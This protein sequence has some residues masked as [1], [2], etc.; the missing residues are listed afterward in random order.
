[1]CLPIPNGFQSVPL[2]KSSTLFSTWIARKPLE[3][4]R[5]LDWN[6]SIGPS[7]YCII[8]CFARARTL[9]STRCSCNALSWCPSPMHSIFYDTYPPVKS[10]SSY[11]AFRRCLVASQWRIRKSLKLLTEFDLYCICRLTW[12]IRFCS[13]ESCAPTRLTLPFLLSSADWLV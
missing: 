2:S 12:N 4:P 13:I 11:C 1:M 8:R 5:K 7:K 9:R 10:Y 6:K 3:N